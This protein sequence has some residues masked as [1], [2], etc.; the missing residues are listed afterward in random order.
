MS[1]ATLRKHKDWLSIQG[2]D[3]EKLSLELE[4]WHAKTLARL[5]RFSRPLS[6][7]FGNAVESKT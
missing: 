1:V 2:I 6:R 7:S 3:K 5:N 4:R